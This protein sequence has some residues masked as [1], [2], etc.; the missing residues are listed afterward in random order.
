MPGFEWIDKKE[1]KIVKKIFYEGGTLLAHGFDKIRKKYYVRD[2]ERISNKYFKSK[3]C[4]A[5]SSGTAAI[6]VALK[7]LGVNSRG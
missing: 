2:F 7:S 4:L 3:N 6:K 1:L 5:V